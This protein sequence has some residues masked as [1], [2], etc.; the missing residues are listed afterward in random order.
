M[1]FPIDK[2]FLRAYRAS[3]GG[4]GEKVRCKSCGDVIQSQHRHDMV[5]CTCK[6][7]AVDGGD[8]YLRLAGKPELIEV[9]RDGAW[10]P[11]AEVHA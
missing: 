1:K 10:K 6:K 11:I 2:E 5:W 9:N 3:L 4:P 7:I 8:S